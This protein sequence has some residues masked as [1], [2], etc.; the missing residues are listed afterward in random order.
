MPVDLLAHLVAPPLCWGCRGRARQAAPL[1]DRCRASL[2]WLRPPGAPAGGVAAFAPLAYQGP[3]REL[4][5][6][7]KYRGARALVGT[8]AAQIA[9]NAPR[10]AGSTLVPVPLHPA[11]ERS[12]GFNQAALLAEAVAARLGLDVADCLERSGRA[13]AQVGRTRAARVAGAHG[14]IRLHPDERAPRRAVIVDDVITTGATLA[15][16]AAALRAA[17]TAEVAALAYARTLAR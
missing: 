3:A 12:R 17:G 9:A 7:L 16:C 14:D 5:R 10:A 1:C 13:P 8:M 4:V 6:A 11:R 15:A 2:M